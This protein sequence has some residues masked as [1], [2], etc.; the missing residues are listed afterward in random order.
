MSFVL[1][2]GLLTSAQEDFEGRDAAAERPTAPLRTT[3][4]SESRIRAPAPAARTARGIRSRC[5]QVSVGRQAW[6]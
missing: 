3:R 4:P 6:R 2:F 5:Q 1:T